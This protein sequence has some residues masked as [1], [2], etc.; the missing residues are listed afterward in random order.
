MFIVGNTPNC[1]Y[2]GLGEKISDL[3]SLRAIQ[4][5]SLW[6]FHQA[7]SLR[8]QAWIALHHIW[9]HP[10]QKNQLEYVP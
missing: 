5:Y 1:S 3:N 9:E 4:G 7:P 6:L 8:V 10:L 2:G